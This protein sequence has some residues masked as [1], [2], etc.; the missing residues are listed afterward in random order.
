MVEN[1]ATEN[2]KK[3]A[4]KEKFGMR[5]GKKRSVGRRRTEATEKREDKKKKRFDK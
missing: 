3:S 4:R 1:E 5:P 2:K